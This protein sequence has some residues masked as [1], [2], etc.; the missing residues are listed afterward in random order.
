MVLSLGLTRLLTPVVRLFRA[1]DPVNVD[2]LPFAA[3]DSRARR[4]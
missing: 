3:L 4:A 2:W 1:R